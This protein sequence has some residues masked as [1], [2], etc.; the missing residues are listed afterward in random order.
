MDP[1]HIRYFLAVADHG[2][3]NAAASAL[4]IAQPTISQALRLL[5]RD[6]KTPLFYRIGRGMVPT[7]AGHALVG[8]ARTILRDMATA[9]GSIP[10]ADGQLRGRVDLRSHPALSSGILPRLVAAFRL[11]HPHVRVTLDVM[12]DDAEATSLLR[13][14]VCE[15]VVGHLPVAGAGHETAEAAAPTALTTLELGTQIYDLALPPGEG[16]NEDDM[17]WDD[18]DAAMVVVP[19]GN[20]HAQRMFEAMSPH[21]QAR[22]PAVVVQNREARLAFALAGVG[23]TWIERTERE[24]ALSHGARVRTMVPALPA[25]YGLVYDAESLSPAA[26]AFV[27]MAV[28]LVGDEASQSAPAAAIVAKNAS[29]AGES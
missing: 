20:L 26:R 19:H 29:E 25:P 3:I 28:E 13:D 16:P 5:E 18:L 15:I 8:P 6:L 27:A 22:R 12:Y 14:A 9:A 11:R 2:S 1:Q 10:D 23:P 4:G 24:R 17:S 7:S 21:Q